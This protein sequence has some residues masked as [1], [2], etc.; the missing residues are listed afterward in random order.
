MIGHLRTSDVFTDD[1]GDQCQR[2]KLIATCEEEEIYMMGSV[3]TVVITH[4]I[5]TTLIPRCNSWIINVDIEP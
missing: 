1:V 3:Y 4:P 2:V 5:A